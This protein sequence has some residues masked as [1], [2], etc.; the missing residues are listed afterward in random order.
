MVGLAVLLFGS[1]I[2]VLYGGPC[3]SGVFPAVAWVLLGFRFSGRRCS[4]LDDIGVRKPFAARLAGFDGGFGRLFGDVARRS[5]RSAGVVAPVQQLRNDRLG[6]QKCG[7]N[8][9]GAPGQLIRLQTLRTPVLPRSLT[10]ADLQMIGENPPDLPIT[11]RRGGAAWPPTCATKMLCSPTAMPER[12]ARGLSIL[13]P[14]LMT[15]CTRTSRDPPAIFIGTQFHVVS[16]SYAARLGSLL[17][18]ALVLDMPEAAAADRRA[19]CWMVIAGA[20]PASFPV[21]PFG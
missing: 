7:V 12:S 21:R 17:V 19:A 9:T 14:R 2:A 4:N 15:V 10:D 5:S 16:I 1:T 18:S 20:D 3:G 6:F 8:L 11:Y 13:V